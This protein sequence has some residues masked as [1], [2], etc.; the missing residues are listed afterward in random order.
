[1]K[2]IPVAMTDSVATSHRPACSSMVGCPEGTV[3]IEALSKHVNLST[4]CFVVA[5]QK[6]TN[7]GVVSRNR[8]ICLK[9]MKPQKGSLLAVAY[10]DCTQRSTSLSVPSSTTA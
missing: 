1:M 8:Q 6:L 2:M 5:S 9:T 3:M 4:V 10:R 7:E